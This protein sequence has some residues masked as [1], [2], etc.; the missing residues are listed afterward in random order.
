[1]VVGRSPPACRLKDIRSLFLWLQLEAEFIDGSHFADVVN[2]IRITG[3]DDHV[4][5]EHGLRQEAANRGPAL[6]HMF[7]GIQEGDEVGDLTLAL[8]KLVHLQQQS[9]LEDLED[10]VSR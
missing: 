4:L 1:M 2:E 7:R 8:V 9:I 6:D 10:G 3:H 5:V